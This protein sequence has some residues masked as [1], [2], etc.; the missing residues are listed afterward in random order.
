MKTQLMTIRR[1]SVGKHAVKLYITEDVRP[2]EID[3]KPLYA[4]IN[5]HYDEPVERLAHIILS[6]FLGAVR[7]EITDCTRNGIIL[8]RVL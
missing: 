8:E 5:L 3:C 6:E 4:L 2:D 1:C 7:V